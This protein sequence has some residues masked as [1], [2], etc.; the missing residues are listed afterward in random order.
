[1]FVAAV[2]A[3]TATDMRAEVTP[4][5]ESYSSESTT[6]GWTTSVE[7]R[8]TP[9]VLS[10]NGDYFL[11]FNQSQ[12]S[13]GTMITGTILNGKAAAGDNFTLTFDMRL[14]SSGGGQYAQYP[15]S[16]SFMDAANVGV[17]FSLVAKGPATGITGPG[18]KVNDTETEVD[19]PNS[20][21]TYTGISQITWCSYKLTRWQGLTFLTITNRETNEMIFERK[22]IEGSS[23]IGGLGDIVCDMK[24]YRSNF[25]IDNIVVRAIEQGDIPDI[26]PVNYTLHYINEENEIIKAD[27]TIASYVGAR[28]IASKLQTLPIMYDGKKYLYKQGNDT[29]TLADDATANTITLVYRKAATYHYTVNATDNNGNVLKQITSS[30]GFEE[31][32]LKVPYPTYVVVDEKL[33]SN[34]VAYKEY[35]E[36]ITLTEDYQVFNIVYSPTTTGNVIY[37]AEAEDV[38]GMTR[39]SAGNSE[40]RSSQ[41]AMGYATHDVKF[42]TLQPGNYQLTFVLYAAVLNQ[43]RSMTFAVGSQEFTHSAT[44]SNYSQNT[45]GIF[46]ITE[47]TDVILKQGGDENCGVDLVYIRRIEGE[48]TFVAEL[49]VADSTLTF[50][51][52]IADASSSTIRSWELPDSVSAPK[53][54][55]YRSRVAKVVFDEAFAE[56]RPKVCSYWFY[57]CANLKSIEGIEHLNTSETTDMRGMFNECSALR[58]LDVSHFDTKN[59]TNMYYMFRNCL[60]LR[61]L[62]VSKFDTGKVTDMG[63]MFCADSL[64]TSLD[65]RNFNTENVTRMTSMF[66]CCESL[67]KLDVSHFNTEKVTDMGWMFNRCMNLTDLDVSNFNTANV[68]NMNDMFHACNNLESIDVSKFNTEKVIGMQYMF[69]ECYPLSS[70]DVSHFNTANVTNMAGMFGWTNLRSLD[71]SSFDTK[72][73]KDMSYMF[74]YDDWL[75]TI[76][77]S[78]KWTTDSVTDSTW[79]FY[80]CI[81]LTGGKGTVYDENHV[82][83][84]YASIDGGADAPGYFTDKSSLGVESI[85]ADSRNNGDTPVYNLRGQRHM[86]PRKGVN[87]VGGK[88]VVIK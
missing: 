14:G 63:W 25:A 4:F 34:Y 62:D 88:K 39:Y 20:G 55:Y 19:L 5:S 75:E 21:Y 59:V 32:E 45:F 87:I 49:N 13:T 86:A 27:T 3:V 37:Y 38:E 82:D 80:D 68:T 12:R 51:K 85:D 77:V 7:G 2:L 17:V 71:L 61:S 10:E 16:V 40:V 78:D 22:V 69:A 33:W 64:L 1:M 9:V 44:A 67:T 56:A 57:Q 65:V 84:N 79:M 18:W 74:C 36:T 66:W 76:F 30:E 11:T 42:T 43:E 15:T 70:V 81:R 60:S 28:V 72:R 73:V 54:Y 8:Y 6:D 46:T 52:G 48:P 23:A 53:W 29:I 31:D 26:K 83:C 58:D 47:P 35:R 50:K 41:A 24:R